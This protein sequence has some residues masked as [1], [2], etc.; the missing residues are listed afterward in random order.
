MEEQNPTG[1]AL[2]PGALRALYQANYDRMLEL[3]RFP[4][5]LLPGRDVLTGVMEDGD[6]VLHS[7]TTE[8]K[9]QHRVKYAVV[10]VGRRSVDIPF[11]DGLR[12]QIET[13]DDGELVLDRD[14]SVR[15]DAPDNHRIY[16]LNRARLSH[17]IPDANLTLLPVRAATVLNSMFGREMFQVRDDLCPISWK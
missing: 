14:Y 16:A 17:G 12:Q 15:W 8:A 9:E 5:T 6:L 3:G 1:D 13:D 2:T 11:D 10:A 7:T 4:V